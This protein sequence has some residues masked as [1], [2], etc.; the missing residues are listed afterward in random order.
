MDLQKVQTSRIILIWV[1]GIFLVSFLTNLLFIKSN[2]AQPFINSF[3]NWD[4]VY[5]LQI[6]EFG[7]LKN[8]DYAFFPIYP[9]FIKFVSLFTGSY[10]FSG[11]LVS[12]VSLIISLIF[13]EKLTSKEGIRISKKVVL[14]LLFFPTSFYFLAVYSESTFLMFTVLSFYF[15]KQE[16]FF[17]TTI[18]A[19]LA[20]GTKILGLGLIAALIYYTL[21]SKKKSNKKYLLLLSPLGLLIYSIYLFYQTGNPFYFV[22]SEQSWQRNLAIP[23]ISIWNGFLDIFSHGINNKNIYVLQ[24]IIFCAFG[25]GFILRSFRFLPKTY[26]IYSLTAI[27]IPLFTST[28]LSIPRFLIVIFPIFIMIGLVKNQYFQIFYQTFS[29][30]LLSFYIVLFINGYWV[31]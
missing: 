21:S 13:F 9:I 6:A 14:F 26:S 16:K 17:L 22:I 1:L 30:L 18:F 20:I 5:Y 3:A 24:D 10:L 27:L 15:L 11:V 12:I 4:G 23:G 28:L 25:L 7:Y 29:V 2:P 31:S 19:S 8:S